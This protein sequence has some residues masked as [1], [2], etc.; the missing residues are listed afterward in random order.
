MIAIRK[1]LDLSVHITCLL[2]VLPL[3]R[4]LHWPAQLVLPLAFLGGFYQDCRRRYPVPRLL[5]NLLALLPFVYYG[6]GLSLTRVVEPVANVLALLLA[7]RLVTE[8]TPR[9]YLQLFVLAVLTLAASTLLSLSPL[10]LLMLILQFFFVVLGLV[11]LTFHGSDTHMRL[12]LR[13]LH[14]L[15]GAGGLLAAGSLLLMLGFF[16]ILPRTPYPLWDVFNPSSS[17]VTGFSEQVRPGAFAATMN[18]GNLAFRVESEPL[19]VEELYWRGLV[20]NYMEG[21]EWRR[22]TPPPEEQSRLSGGRLVEQVVYG[23]ARGDSYLM[24][25]D[26]TQN[27]AG[28]R[29]QGSQDLVYRELRSRRRPGSYRSESRLGGRLTAHNVDPRFYLQLPDQISPRIRQAA[30]GLTGETAVAGEI[31]A[32]TK[33]FFRDQK[34]SYA[35]TDLPGTEQPLEDFLFESRRG[36]CEFFASAFAVMLRLQGVPARLV[37]GYYGGQYNALAG[38]YSVREDRAHVWVEALEDGVWRRIDPSRLAIN[39]DSAPFAGGGSRSGWGRRLLDGVEYYWNRTVVSY[40]LGRQAQLVR[41]AV[42]RTRGLSLKRPSPTALAVL[43]GVGAGLVAIGWL[44]ARLLVSAERRLLRRYLRLLR[45]RFYPKGIPDH[46][47]LTSLARGTGDPRCLEFA[48][49]FN[50]AVYRDRPLGKGEKD[51]LKRLLRMLR[52]T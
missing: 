12:S 51:R 26:R 31:I 36:Y 10:F 11:L 33:R 23:E 46:A 22:I 35:T 50:G 43:L 4:E 19:P 37:G 9:E 48:D 52:R 41:G 47:G 30:A 16:V 49:I 6:A 5:W 32:A 24:V 38:F 27:I 15:T 1:L 42:F 14:S 2:G 25:L 34:L 3:Y 29:V 20:L 17:A 8:K 40:D 39:A 18:S 45:R 7:L 21:N 13:S 28:L 44:A